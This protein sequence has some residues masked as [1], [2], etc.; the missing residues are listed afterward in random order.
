VVTTN[1]RQPTIVLAA[2]A[3][4]IVAVIAFLAGH[5]V[6]KAVTAISQRAVR[7]A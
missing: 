3:W 7:I 1:V 4:H 6:D 2:V 5:P